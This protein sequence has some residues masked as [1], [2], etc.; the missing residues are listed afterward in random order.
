MAIK[1][2][3]RVPAHFSASVAV[4]PASEPPAVS[5]NR[6]SSRPTKPPIWMHDYVSTDPTSYVEPVKDP[7]WVAAMKSEIQ[8][9]QDNHTWSLV[10]LPAGKKPIGCKWVFKVKYTS[11]GAV[12][13]Y[14]AQLVATGYSQQEGLDYTE[15]FSPV[16]KM[17]T[18]RFLLGLPA[19]RGSMMSA[20]YISPFMD[21][22]KAPRQWNKKLTDALV[23]LGLSQSHFDY[24]LF[25]KTVQGELVIVL[26]YVDDLLVTG[27][28]AA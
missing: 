5:V 4:S 16:A 19:R 28:N 17:V 7:H 15:T 2:D 9:L 11:S 13:R 20:N 6:K 1:K 26:V 14:K 22:N 24:S 8:A 21:S 3:F 10:E 25:T 12:E 23:Q 18:V 27:S